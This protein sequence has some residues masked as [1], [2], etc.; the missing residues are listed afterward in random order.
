MAKMQGKGW[1]MLQLLRRMLAQLQQRV[2]MVHRQAP[3]RQTQEKMRNEETANRRKTKSP[4]A[5]AARVPASAARVVTAAANGG[6][7]A[8]AKAGAF[9]SRF[10]LLVR[11]STA[12]FCD[13]ETPW[14]KEG[15]I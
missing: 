14:N 15:A 5:A 3:A 4:V 7:V 11:A 12:V 9:I 13:Q 6:G 1:L 10:G 8:H 2:G